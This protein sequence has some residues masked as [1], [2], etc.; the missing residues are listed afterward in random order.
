MSLSYPEI[1]GFLKRTPCSSGFSLN[2]GDL[3]TLDVSNVEVSSDSVVHTKYGNG[4]GYHF[5]MLVHRFVCMGGEG[6]KVIIFH[7]CVVF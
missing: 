4:T 1:P 5:N 3:D 6:V 7:G 2:I